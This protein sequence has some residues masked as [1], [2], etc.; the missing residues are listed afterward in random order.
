MEKN[1]M[2]TAFTILFGLIVLVAISTY[3]IPAG[4][5]N[6]LADG[7]PIA[8]TYHTVAQ[9]GQN[10]GAILKA[11]LEGLY[12]AIDIAAFILMVGGF[13]GVVM[14]TGAIDTGIRS[15]VRRLHGREK[16][17]IPI[18]MFI[19]A[20]GGTTFG[21]WEET[22]AFFP[23]LLP[24]FLAAGY[25]TVVPV[26][27]ILLGAGVGSLGSTVNPFATGIAAGFAGVRLSDGMI[28]RLIMLAVFLVTAIYFV[29]RYAERVRLHPETSVVAAYR[30]EHRAFFLDKKKGETNEDA[31]LTVRQKLVLWIFA[32]VFL[33]MVYSVIPFDDMGLD[34][35]PTLSWWFPELSALF[36]AGA[37]LA[38]ICYGMPEKVLVAN[39]L[40]GTKD[41]LSV[42]FIIGISRGIIVIMNNGMITDTILYWGESALQGT[43]GWGFILLSYL[44]YI[45]LA[46]LI[47]SSSG[48]ATLVTPIMSPLADFSGVSR[49]LSIT[50]FQSASGFL[51]LFTPTSAVIMGALALGRIPYNRWLKFSWRYL[52]FV[53]LANAAFLAAGALIP[54]LS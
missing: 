1:R 23:L 14:E 45:P 10:I 32:A 22:M 17:M 39:F 43:A 31:P 46:F 7:E 2:P 53:F 50:A 5:Y 6:V 49:A 21:M 15:V 36:L 33:I 18:L 29:M 4:Q 28:L 35:L 3:L 25:D 44:I 34:F 30:E 40:N 13:L 27:V 41:L 37:L 8:G 26:A 9:H 54:G 12:D 20:L 24:I 51:N 47:P 52:L 38:G 48:L 19:F 16:Y 11:P 42:A